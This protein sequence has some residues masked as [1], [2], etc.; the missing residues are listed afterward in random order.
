ME[1]EKEVQCVQRCVIR[2]GQSFVGNDQT[3]HFGLDGNICIG[4]G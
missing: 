4:Q 2:N 1:K 3:H